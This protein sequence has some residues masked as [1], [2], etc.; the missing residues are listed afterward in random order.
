MCNTADKAGYKVHR[1]LNCNIPSRNHSEWPSVVKSMGLTFVAQEDAPFQPDLS[2]N[3]YLYMTT[4][5]DPYD[6]I[7]SH[8]HHEF[9]LNTFTFAKEGMAR[10]NCSIDIGSASL[11]DIILSECFD[12]PAFWQVNSNFYHRMFADCSGRV[13]TERHSELA[14]AALNLMSVIILTN[15]PEEYDR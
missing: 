5:R 11:S 2:R 7:V 10:R 13:C 6:R 8:L 9:C 15:T 1:K 12:T 4:I 14:K 3:D